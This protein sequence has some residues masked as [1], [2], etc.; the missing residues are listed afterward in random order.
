MFSAKVKHVHVFQVVGNEVTMITVPI[1]KSLHRNV[2]MNKRALDL[3]KKKKSQ[4]YRRHYT[5]DKRT[6]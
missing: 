5:I 3:K 4:M 1:S 2:I 6:K